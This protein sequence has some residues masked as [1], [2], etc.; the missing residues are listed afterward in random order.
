MASFKIL[1]SVGR[2][3]PTGISATPSK[4][5][6]KIRGSK[7]RQET[8]P[9]SEARGPL[10][11]STASKQQLLFFF[12]LVCLRCFFVAASGRTPNYFYN[13]GYIMPHI[14]AFKLSSCF[15]YAW[16]LYSKE[17]VYFKMCLFLYLN[18]NV[19]SKT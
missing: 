4:E 7:K 14:L 9:E 16:F 5:E 3:D 17:Y 11:S 19:H 1:I 8:P 12:W 6:E 15:F 2:E 10:L 18:F 13:T